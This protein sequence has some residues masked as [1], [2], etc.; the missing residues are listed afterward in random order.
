MF[1]LIKQS[2]VYTFYLNSD[3]GSNLYIGDTLLIDNNGVHG[4]IEKSGEIV[5]S[6]GYY[7]IRV[8]YFQGIGGKGLEVDMKAPGMKKGEIPQNLLFHKKR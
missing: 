3:D 1:T 6:Q 8:T 7:P 2:R 5:L 4:M